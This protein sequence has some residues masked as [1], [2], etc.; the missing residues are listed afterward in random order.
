MRLRAKFNLAVILI[1]GV[2]LL[3]TSVVSYLTEFQQAREEVLHEAEVLLSMALATRSYTVRE[4]RPLLW[5]LEEEVDFLEET[6]PSYAAQTTFQIFN[7]EF[8]DF[9]YREAALNPTNPRDLARSWEVDIIQ[10]MIAVN[11]GQPVVDDRQ[12]EQ[13]R[14]LYLAR[15]IRITDEG[16]L[17]CHSTPDVAPASMIA[18]YGADGGFGWQM[19]EIIGAQIVAVPM[20][21]A[22]QQA[23]TSTLTLAGSLF[24]VFTLILIAINIMLDRM[25]IQPLRS[26][27]EVTDR[28][29]RGDID[30]EELEAT[31]NDE[32]GR[33]ERA[34]NRLR[35]SLKKAMD[36]AQNGSNPS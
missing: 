11:D 1:F 26:L 4:V 22:Y 5:Q 21:I 24:S 2:G 15:P 7:E 13:G 12:T 8:S 31:R 29:S 23:R 20:A 3:I 19:E 32:I 10:N 14:I 35:R 16:C 30:I 17:E 27:A 28:Y 18:D 34:T 25:F 9:T 33:L 36:I 6:V